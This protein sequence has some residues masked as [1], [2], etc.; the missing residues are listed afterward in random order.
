MNILLPGN[1]RKSKPQSRPGTCLLRSAHVHPA[2]PMALR[3]EEICKVPIN[4]TRAFREKRVLRPTRRQVRAPNAHPGR[5]LR[6]AYEDVGR[7]LLE[8]F[9]GANQEL[10]GL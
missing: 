5:A 8:P 6:A 7:F 2:I 3:V 9:G 4:G 1:N 10:P